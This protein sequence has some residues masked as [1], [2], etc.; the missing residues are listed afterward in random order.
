M[1]IEWKDSTL[2]RRGE[3]RG[4]PRS[5]SIE[6]GPI[7]IT[8]ISEHI[9]YPGMWVM[10]CH[11]LGINTHPLEVETADE[12][13]S[14]AIEVASKRVFNLDQHVKRIKHQTTGATQ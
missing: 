13:K 10:A 2:W 8:V 9:Y 3:E 7:R 14:K 6:S 5:W 12:A 1:S 11:G 4:E